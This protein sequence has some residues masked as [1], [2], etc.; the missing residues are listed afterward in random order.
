[1]TGKQLK[2]TGELIIVISFLIQNLL[3]DYYN[4]KSESLLNSAMSQSIIDKGSE[5]KELK[6]FIAKFPND[7]ITEQ[8]YRTL[9]IN[10]AAQKIAFAKI[11]QITSL[12]TTDIVKSKMKDTL[13]NASKNVHSFSDYMN[14]ITK[15]NTLQIVNESTTKQIQKVNS[16]KDFYRIL[17]I[18]LYIIG[19]IFLVLAI[20][21]EKN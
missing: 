12:D 8:Q 21:K 14:F 3:F 2:I 20:R 17:F 16:N 7:S 19:S 5:L 18:F 4:D 15:V 11:V 10:L 1:M 13:S 9:N 6:Y